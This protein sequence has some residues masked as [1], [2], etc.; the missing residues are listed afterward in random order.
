MLSAGEAPAQLRYLEK[1]GLPALFQTTRTLPAAKGVTFAA[2]SPEPSLPSQLPHASG[3]R[4]PRATAHPR[5]ICVSQPTEGR[6]TWYGYRGAS[7]VFEA[8]CGL[9]SLAWR[10]HFAARPTSRGPEM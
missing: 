10:L 3:G 6:D 2:R 8:P 1:G 5:D 4:M 9:F 7:T